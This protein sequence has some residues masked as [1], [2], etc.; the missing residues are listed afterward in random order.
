MP[1]GRRPHPR[2]I[3]DASSC[4]G[5]RGDPTAGGGGAQ[6]PGGCSAV[7]ADDTTAGRGT[8][9]SAVGGARVSDIV[10]AGS[11]TRVMG[12]ARTTEETALGPLAS[13]EAHRGD[14]VS[15]KPPTGQHHQAG[16]SA[17]VL[18]PV[19][20]AGRQGLS[21]LL[22]CSA[23]GERVM[24]PLAG[25]EHHGC[26]AWCHVC[27][28]DP[29]ASERPDGH[30]GSRAPAPVRCRRFLTDT[31]RDL[32]GS[33]GLP[34]PLA[35]A[36]TGRQDALGHAAI[37]GARAGH[38]TAS[39]CQVLLVARQPSR[40]LGPRGRTGRDGQQTMMAQAPQAMGPPPGG[41]WP[42]A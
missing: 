21:D 1:E 28:D 13:L 26:H 39:L 15:P 7:E 19:A 8:S 31:V 37:G 36:A 33:S 27:A 10:S 5:R 22:G 30:T 20:R 2:A 34:S 40:C 41:C 42:S 3:A 17:E 29:T 38:D 9:P 32:R 12:R 16:M 4:Q 18:G 6:G 35:R 24:P 25:G 14:G 11:P 23:W